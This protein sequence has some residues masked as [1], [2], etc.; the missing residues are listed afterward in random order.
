K[1][2]TYSLKNKYIMIFFDRVFSLHLL[3]FSLC[4]FL[5]LQLGDN[6]GDMKSCRL[7]AISCQVIQKL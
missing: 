5:F 4:E 7:R 3:S 1:V 2:I 6:G